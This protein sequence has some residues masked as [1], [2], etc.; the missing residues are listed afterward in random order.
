M[1]LRTGT[2]WDLETQADEILRRDRGTNRKHQE[3]NCILNDR[4]LEYRYSHEVYNS[5]GFPDVAIVSGVYGR[6]WNPEAN[7]HKS[8][9]PADY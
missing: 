8:I 2:D 5:T 1:K 4:Q 9:H 3:V 7:R 6:A